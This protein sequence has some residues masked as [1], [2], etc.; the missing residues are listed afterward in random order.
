MWGGV[1]P[2]KAIHPLDNDGLINVLLP[3]LVS[4]LSPSSFSFLFSSSLTSEEVEQDGSETP[5]LVATH[6]VGNAFPVSSPQPLS[7]GVPVM[8][9]HLYIIYLL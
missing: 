7:A 8:C 9:N 4:H 3:V 1:G 5:H 6:C 2:Q